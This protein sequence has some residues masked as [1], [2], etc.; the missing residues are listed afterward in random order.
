MRDLREKLE[1]ERRRHY[2][3][4]QR[5]LVGLEEQLTA[6]RRRNH[7]EEQKILK[8]LWFRNKK[9]E[10]TK[11]SVKF[12][13]MTEKFSYYHVL[14]LVALTGSYDCKLLVPALYV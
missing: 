5:I 3:E 6:E 8:A 7:E 13:H 4:E 1:E 11:V 10:E 2:E 12:T 9:L 14:L